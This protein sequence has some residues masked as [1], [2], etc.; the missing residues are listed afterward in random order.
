MK[1]IQLTQGKVAIVDDDDYEWLSLWRWCACN[2][3]CTHYAK[4][5]VKLPGGR[6]TTVFMHREILGLG[7]DDKLNVDHKNHEGLDNR[8]V[9]IRAV[10]QQENLFNREALGVSWRK[11]RHKFRA[12]IT[13][14]QKQ[15]HL[16]HYPTFAEALAARAAGKRKYHKILG[17]MAGHKS[18]I[19][20]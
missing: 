19:A 6:W 17:R 2:Y 1:E 13:V 20:S 8:R 5:N 15:I 9:N 4:R 14:G 3:G 10:T 12:Y 16:G 7:P 11:D 18:R